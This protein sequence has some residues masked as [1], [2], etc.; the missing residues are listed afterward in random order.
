MI[1]NCGI[2]HDSKAGLHKISTQT[3][4]SSKVSERWILKK[5]PKKTT[6]S[7][8]FGTKTQLTIWKRFVP[9]R[10]TIFSLDC[11]RQR[12]FFLD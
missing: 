3:D 8:K 5:Q 2:L 10:P 4:D 6:K 12:Q 9:N 7:Q 11:C 1:V